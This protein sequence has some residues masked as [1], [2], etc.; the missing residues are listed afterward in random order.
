[1]EAVHHFRLP[2]AWHAK[3]FWPTGNHGYDVPRLLHLRMVLQAVV[4]VSVLAT[5]GLASSLQNL[6]HVP[7]K[8]KSNAPQTGGQRLFHG[9]VKCG[10]ELKPR[11]NFGIVLLSAFRLSLHPL[12]SRGTT[13]G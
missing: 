2:K 4:S 12:L 13:P 6:Y 1:M 3:S 11:Q 9:S 5:A 7:Y 10:A 8:D